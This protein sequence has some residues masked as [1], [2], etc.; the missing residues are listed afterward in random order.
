[1]NRRRFLAGTVGGMSLLAGCN[2][3][4]GSADDSKVNVKW[5]K[6]TGRARKDWK[7]TAK[8]K[9]KYPKKAGVV[10]HERTRIYENRTLQREV[11]ED[12]RAVRPD[13]GDVL[14]QSRGPP[15]VHGEACNCR[16]DSREPPA[17]V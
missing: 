6:L 10:P 1:M 12:P 13:A 8:R 2:S 11:K 16:P 4:S 14:R 7:Q 15:G 5:P 3:P 17:D 9:K